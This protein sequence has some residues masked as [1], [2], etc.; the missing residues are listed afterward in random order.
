MKVRYRVVHKR[1]SPIEALFK[2]RTYTDWYIAERRRWFGWRKL[3]IFPTAEA[4]EQACTDHA[5]GELLDDGGR[6]ISEFTRRDEE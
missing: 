3:G 4:A 2:G 1:K 5:G 6:I